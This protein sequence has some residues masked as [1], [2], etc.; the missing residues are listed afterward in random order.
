[1]VLQLRPKLIRMK[2]EED[3]HPFEENKPDEDRISEEGHMGS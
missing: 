2:R 3:A 1:L